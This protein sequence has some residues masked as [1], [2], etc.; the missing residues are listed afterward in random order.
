M[1][2]TDLEKLVVQ[3]SADIK[4]FENAMNRARGVTNKQL[5]A[6]EKRA[7]SASSSIGGT[8][9]GLGRAFAAAFVSSEFVRGAA[10]L[11]E[12]ATRIDNSLRVAGVSA[13]ELDGVYKRLAA[14]A[15]KNGAP[16][17]SLAALYGKAAQAQKEL[18]VT[19]AELE[20]FTGNVAVA[21]RVSSTDAQ[22]A[23]GALLQLGQALGSGKVQAEEFGSILDGTPAIAQAVAAGL[24]EAGGSVSKLKSLIVDGKVS[25]EAFFR[26]FEAGAP[27]LEQKAASATTTLSSA[28]ENLRTSLIG[29][30]REFNNSTGAS[31]N[32]AEGINGVS[33]RISE[34]DVAGFIKKL[35]DAR[36]ELEN[37]LAEAGNSDI[38]RKLNEAM[39]TADSKGNIINPAVDEAQTKIAALEREIALLQERIEQ[40]SSLGFD[41]TEALARIAQVRGEL[42]ALQA[43]AA[44]LPATIQTPSAA[45]VANAGGLNNYVDNQNANAGTTNGQMGGSTIRGGKRNPPPVKPVSINDYAPPPGSKSGGGG[46]KK[47]R[48]GGQSAFAS[49]TDQIK[50]RTAALQAETAALASVN[51]LVDDY[52]FALEKARAEQDLLAAAQK[53]GVAITPELKASISAL[54]G[55]YAQASAEA[56][57]LAQSQDRARQAADDFKSTGKDI[58]GG[59]ISDLRQGKSA[60]DALA[61]ALDKIVDKLVD[62]SLNAAFGIGGGGG[63]LL[64]LFGFA[65]GGI[66]AHGRPRPLPRFAKGGVARSASIFGEAGPEAAVP[67]PDGRSIPVKFK[68]PSIPRA[69][70]SGGQSSYAPVYHIDARGADA[71]AVARLERSLQERDRT[72]AKR[73]AGYSRTQ[74]SRKTRA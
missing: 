49:E 63:G 19:S 14:A 22:S 28:T 6:I 71:A 23:S 8:L 12:A 25:S 34:F 4:K 41:N 2:A 68:E 47:G 5:S 54:A 48:S 72:E 30:V 35:R 74:Q 11:S 13:Q 51:P 40:N 56:E 46:A 27:M 43:Q 20:K 59:F 58:V 57:K 61:G 67:L 50:E 10:Q 66:A 38:I 55:G 1:A 29:A 32:L 3:L 37:F 9:G 18:G 42:A 33:R 73:V 65:D 53:S 7:A 44:N 69:S 70:S 15:I 31:E 16:I 17:E 45:D 26:A 64:S 60:A 62:V 39:G 52:G 24:K 21:L 36:N